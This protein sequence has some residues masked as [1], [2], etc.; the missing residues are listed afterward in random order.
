MTKTKKIVV[1]REPPPDLLGYGEMLADVARLLESGRRAAARSVNAV[2]TAT[3]WE[4]GRRIVEYEQGGKARA[5]YGEGLIERL[6]G[7]LTKR[8]GRGFSRQNLQ[9]MRSFYVA[10]P[11]EQICQTV[12]GGSPGVPIRPTLSG[13]SPGGRTARIVQTASA[14]SPT[15]PATGPARFPLPWSHYVRL[16]GVRNREAREFYE[17][18]A[19]RGGWTVRQLDRQIGS[20]FYERTALSRN[21]TA[22]LRHGEQRRPEDAV[23]PEQEIKDPLVLEF[24][25]LKD[26]YSES[27]LEAALITRLESFLL[28][29]GGDFTFVGRQRRLRVGD[30]WFRLDLLF[31]HRRLR[32]LVI[33]DLKLDR[34]TPGDAG[35]MNLYVNYAREHW[36]LP[37]ENPPV[38]LILCAGRDAAVAQYALGGLSNKILAAEY[39]TALPEEKVLADELTRTRRLL[40]ARRSTGVGFDDAADEDRNKAGRNRRPSRRSTKPAERPPSR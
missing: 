11:A 20:Q 31:F 9:L 8:F 13:D 10:Y 33:I 18:E 4:I 15:R 7:D 37:D 38:G 2:M 17:T 14:Q 23:T 32:C 34:L 36:T 16:L 1:R 12:S 24:L 27:D 30:S 6:A 40:E 29:L 5:G 19:L 3:Y 21:K 22:M 26:E 35:Q 28:E 25:D 39:R